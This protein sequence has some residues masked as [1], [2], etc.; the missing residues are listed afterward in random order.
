MHGL[1]QVTNA[2]KSTESRER[3]T[4]NFLN[5]WIFF[6]C[7]FQTFSTGQRGQVRPLTSPQISQAALFLVPNDFCCAPKDHL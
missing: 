5:S 7:F 2:K 1:R 4:W 3:L 6:P